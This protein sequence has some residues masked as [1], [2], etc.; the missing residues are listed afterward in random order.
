VIHLGERECSIQRRHQKVIEEAPSPIVDDEM[1]AS[2]GAAAV[3]LALRLGYE[4]AGTVE[5]LVDDQ[6]DPQ[7]RRPFWFLEINTRLQVEHPV[8]ECVTGIDLVRE[9]LRIAQ[10][11]PLG[12]SQ[13]DITISGHAI[14]A[15]LYAEDPA[16]GFLP[17]SGTIRGWRPSSVPELRWDSGVREGTTIGTR[18]D[19]MLAKVIAHR[20]TRPEAAGALALGLQRTHIAGIT[21]NRDLLVNVLRSGRYLDG[22]TTTDFL[23]A[24]VSPTAARHD[25]DRLTRAAVGLAL[26]MQGVSRSQAQALAFVPTGWRNGRLPDQQ[27][28]FAAGDEEITVRYRSRRDG[29]FVVNGDLVARVFTWSD[30]GIDVELAGRRTRLALTRW[31]DRAVVNDGTGDVVFRLVPRF[32]VP[33]REQAAG[34]LNAPMPGRVIEVRVEEGEAV[35]AGQVLMILEAMKMEHRISAPSPGVVARVLVVAGMQV[36]LGAPL[37]VVEEGTSGSIGDE[38]GAGQQAVGEGS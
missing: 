18:F 27:V 36:E 29:S 13:D 31:D 33:G 25:T 11:E 20:A 23:D 4:S 34:G 26:W 24:G 14:E 7:G 17:S 6:T 16:S 28:T 32:V 15:R 21:T 37:L 12:R 3:A 9:Q 8:T 10:G 30:D 19:P 38:A 22:D 5:F 2:M 35:V 1:R